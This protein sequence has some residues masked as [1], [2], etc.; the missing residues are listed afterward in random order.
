[1]NNSIA[2]HIQSATLTIFLITAAT[3][4]ALAAKTVEELKKDGYSCE[5]I[6]GAIECRK[7]KDD[8]KYLCETNGSGCQTYKVGTKVKSTADKVR[9]INTPTKTLST[10]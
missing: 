10:N 8:P 7:G 4:S 2:R 1:M 5:G 3:T 6:T 9:A